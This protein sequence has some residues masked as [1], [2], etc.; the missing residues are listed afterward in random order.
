MPCLRARLYGQNYTKPV[1][2]RG[3]S[4]LRKE[5]YLVSSL[6]ESFVLNSLNLEVNLQREAIH[7]GSRSQSD[8][9]MNLSFGGGFLLT[10]IAGHKLKGTQK[11]R[12]K[13]D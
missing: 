6:D 8:R 1:K 2:S 9:R 3:K 13:R 11:A 5:K 7:F 4:R 10:S 12:W